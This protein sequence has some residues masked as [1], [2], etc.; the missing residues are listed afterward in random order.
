MSFVKK[1]LIGYKVEN[2]CETFPVTLRACLAPKYMREA[3]RSLSRER[4]SSKQ[5]IKSLSVSQRATN[6]IRENKRAPVVNSE[7]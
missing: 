6:P 3:H 5:G 7:S 2:K 1:T 4:E